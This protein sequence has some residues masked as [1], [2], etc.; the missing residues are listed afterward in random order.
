MRLQITRLRGA[1]IVEAVIAAACL[2]LFFAGLFAVSGQSLRVL[3][4]GSEQ[5]AATFSLQQR[6]E[7]MRRLSW[8]Q[9]T[10]G[11]Y[12]RD[13]VLNNPSG[14]A[15]STSGL[16]EQIA[17]NA[18]PTATTPT[19]VTR[20]PTG[21]AVVQASNPALSTASMLRI[22]AQVSWAEVGGG[23]NS[24]QFTTLITQGGITR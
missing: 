13:N 9:I 21:G 22:D 2:A 6:M 1:S 4:S 16:S 18:Y 20:G 24:R 3:R 14:S 8:A 11:A 19:V 23:T 7:E 15:A 10:D 5:S 12:L 17:I